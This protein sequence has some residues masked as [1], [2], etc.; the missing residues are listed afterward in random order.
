MSDMGD[1]MIDYEERNWQD[2]AEKFIEK[3]R[4]DWEQFVSDMFSQYI[5]DIEPPDHWGEDR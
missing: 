4:N 5:A 1:R 3:H 2:L